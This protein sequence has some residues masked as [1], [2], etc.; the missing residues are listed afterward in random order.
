MANSRFQYVRGFESEARL[1]PNTW[2]VVRIDGRGFHKFSAKHG[3]KKPNDARAI[4]L[5]NAAAVACMNEF[6]DIV[7]AYGESDEYS[8]VFDKRTQL[9]SRR[10]DKIMSSIVSFFSSTYVMQWPQ[11][12]VDAEGQPE[13]L[14]ATPH[15][16]GRCVLYPTLENLR[17]YVAWRQVDCHINNLYNTTFWTLV[18]KGGLTEY[19][20]EQRLVGTFSKDKNELLFSEFGINYNEEPLM[21]RKGSVLHWRRIP[22]TVT[23]EGPTSKADPTPVV[24][25]VTRQKLTVIVDHCD[26]LQ[27]EFWTEH[28]D[29]FTSSSVYANGP[30]EAK[31]AAKGRGRKAKHSSETTTIVEPKEAA[32]AASEASQRK[33]T[34]EQACGE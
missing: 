5:M 22:V 23:K 14:V 33:R 10:G 13:P 32:P 30:R 20:A 26:L 15:F 24:R 8:F 28:A 17:D 9:F 21:F 6:P 11:H 19:E 1:L 29:V 7:M 18:L 12:M 2:I 4:N 31:G 16:D 34:A 25:T 3:F 27:E